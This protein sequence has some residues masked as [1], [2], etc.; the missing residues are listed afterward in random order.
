MKMIAY[1]LP[2]FHEIPENDEWWGKGFTEWTNVKKGIPLY[3]G[4]NQPR[5]P[6][7]GYYSLNNKETMQRQAELANKY[8]ISGM[9]FYHY[10]FNG[11]LLLEKPVSNLLRWADIPMN[12]M[13]VWANHSWIRSWEGKSTILM[14]QQYGGETDWKNHF[15][16]FLPFFKDDRYIKINGKPAL[17]LYNPSGIPNLD[18]MIE[19]WNQLA[20]ANGLNGIYVIESIGDSEEKPHAKLSNAAALRAP[21]IATK[22]LLKFKIFYRI[23]KHPNLQ[24]LIPGCYPCK[25]SYKSAQKNLIKISK[26]YDCD[27]DIIFGEYVGWDNTCRHGKRGSVAMG[28]SPKMFEKFLSDICTIANDRGSD[29]LFINA[30]NEW[31]EGMY[32]EPDKTDYYGYLEAVKN[33]SENDMRR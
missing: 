12:Y 22:D 7:E 31:A 16:Y 2:Q 5:V 13:F 24:K 9:A 33:A 20:V 15:E 6:L 1:Y 11:K 14:E 25:Y 8:G 26:F 10:W 4:H 23:K 3:N 28:V 30:W 29:Y 32:L 17:M 27:K 19:F 21:N 18:E